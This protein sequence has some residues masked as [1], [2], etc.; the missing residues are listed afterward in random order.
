[1]KAIRKDP[2]KPYGAEHINNAYDSLF[3]D[4]IEMYKNES[5]ISQYPWD[6]I[7][8]QTDVN[9]LLEI[10]SSSNVES[11]AKLL[12]GRTL[13]SK[14]VSLTQKELLGVVIEISQNNGLGTIAAF[15]DG[16]IRYIN[17]QEDLIIWETQTNISLDMIADLFKIS[18]EFL[19]KSVLPIIARET[20]PEVGN[21]R[22]SFLA[23]DGL[24]ALEKNF[25]KVHKGDFAESIL[26]IGVKLMLFLANQKKIKKRSGCINFFV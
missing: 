14:G 25:I 15:K 12:A 23:I 7:F 16:S 2:E 9:Q 22:I 26:E 8:S 11:R 10:T 6:I 1:M 3:A 4:E 13:I 17:Y 5:S 20:F 21:V 18:E 24:R 19:K